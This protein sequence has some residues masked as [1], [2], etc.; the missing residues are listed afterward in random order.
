MKQHLSTNICCQAGL[1][2]TASN[3]H[4]QYQCADTHTPT[5]IESVRLD[6]EQA[7]RDA[8]LRNE[9]APSDCVENTTWLGTNAKS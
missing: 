6:G 2:V 1:A 7:I 8:L 4:V 3:I 5:H 9:I